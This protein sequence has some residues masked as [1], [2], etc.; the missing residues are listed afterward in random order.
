MKVET[1]PINVCF[2]ADILDRN[3]AN[4]HVVGKL[5]ESGSD[6]RLCFSDSSIFLFH[7]FSNTPYHTDG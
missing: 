5:P 2:L 1:A 6:G 3:A 4:G 7:I